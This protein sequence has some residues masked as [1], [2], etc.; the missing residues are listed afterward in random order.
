MRKNLFSVINRTLFF[1]CLFVLPSHADINTEIAKYIVSADQRYNIE[2]KTHLSIIETESGFSPYAIGVVLKKE[3]AYNLNNELKKEKIKCKVWN[4]KQ[5][6]I[7]SINPKSKKEALVALKH[8]KETGSNRY[9]LGICQINKAKIDDYKWSE[10]KIL[11]EVEYSIERSAMIIRNCM[12]LHKSSKKAL[13]C[14]NKGESG[15][16]GGYLYYKKVL[17]NYNRIY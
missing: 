7:V 10:V 2:T 4:W 11:T 6:K 14:Y 5:K 16:Y 1:L 9:D 13:E 8:V 12:N 3:K 17:K 15:R